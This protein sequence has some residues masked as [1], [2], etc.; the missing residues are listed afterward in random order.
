[1]TPE[2]P[3]SVE[4]ALSR[5]TC[6]CNINFQ[7]RKIARCRM[8]GKFWSS[9]CCPQT[10]SKTALSHT[11]AVFRRPQSLRD[12][13]MKRTLHCKEYGIDLWLPTYFEMRVYIP[14]CPWFPGLILHVFFHKILSWLDFLFACGFI[15]YMWTHKKFCWYYSLQVYVSLCV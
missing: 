11:T 14:L 1:M 9:W 6:T 12:S 8:T 4:T 15:N 2:T 3:L 13:Q 10:T 5:L 7:L